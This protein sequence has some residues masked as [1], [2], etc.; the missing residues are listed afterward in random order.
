[1]MNKVLLT[2]LLT[3]ATQLAFAG[4][5]VV[6]DHEEAIMSTNIAQNKIEA[7]K[8]KPDYARMMAQA[9]S[10]RA[11]IEA[12][13]K[14]ASSKGMTWGAE[15]KAEHRKKVEYIQADFKLAAQKIQGE[16]QAVVQTIVAEMQPKLEE[17]LTKYVETNDVD[18]VLKKQV[19]Y[20]A[21]PVV[22]IT[23]III[24]EMNKLK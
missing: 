21:R 8:A 11:D 24:D 18:M 13:N 5:I 23:P 16:N 22:D 20:I 2:L 1:M 12:L 4:K 17:V 6:F 3:A 9:E 7:L 14:E 10:F 19:S 15:E